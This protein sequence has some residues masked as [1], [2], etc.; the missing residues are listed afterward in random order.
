MC[1]YLQIYHR[2]NS[3][4]LFEHIVRVTDNNWLANNNLGTAMEHEGRL[5][6]VITHYFEAIRVGPSRSALHHNPGLVCIGKWKV[7]EASRHLSGAV[8]VNPKTT[9]WPNTM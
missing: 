6:E 3:I 7:K 9:R 2:K 5:D 4:T 1:G 8:R